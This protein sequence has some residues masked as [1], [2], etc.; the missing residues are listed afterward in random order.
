MDEKLLPRRALVDRAIASLIEIENAYGIGAQSG[1]RAPRRGDPA[2]A[3]DL[4]RS[5]KDRATGVYGYGEC[6][7]VRAP[8]SGLRGSP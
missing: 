1:W 4:F 6:R 2:G 8:I 7:R 3:G 5:L